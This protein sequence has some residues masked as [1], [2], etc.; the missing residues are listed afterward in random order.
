MSPYGIP[1]VTA[2]PTVFTACRRLRVAADGRVSVVCHEHTRTGSAAAGHRS[3]NRAP[4][5]PK[6]GTSATWPGFGPAGWLAVLGGILAGLLAFAG[7]EATFDLIPIETMPRDVMGTKIWMPTMESRSAGLTKNGALTFGLLG[8]CLGLPGDGRRPGPAIDVRR[9]RRHA[10]GNGPGS[11][12]G[13]QRLLALLAL[14][15]HG[16]VALLRSR[17]DPSLGMHGLIW[18]SVGAGAGL[19]FAVGLGKP[20]RGLPGPI[21]GL[22]GA[23]LGTLAFEVIGA[24]AFPLAECDEPISRTWVTRLMARLLVS[25]GAAVTVGLSLAESET[26]AVRPSRRGR[27][28]IARPALTSSQPGADLDQRPESDLLKWGLARVASESEGGH[29]GPKGLRSKAWC[30]I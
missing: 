7:G 11:G 26:A 22:L 6:A 10:A 27:H 9:S 4:A 1:A 8:L 16:T 23:L 25:V 24:V 28:P 15:H 3:P 12:P 2:P 21:A 18:G 13:A 19:A 29:G 5:A 30:A 14:V 17:P 20:R